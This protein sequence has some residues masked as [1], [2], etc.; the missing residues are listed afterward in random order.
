MSGFDLIS[1]E[2]KKG[3]YS[4]DELWASFKRVFSTKTA[5]SSSYKFVFL[6]SLLDCIDRYNKITYS[7]YEVFERFTEIYWILVVKYGLAQNN[8]PKKET[9]VEQIL[10][11]YVGCTTDDKKVKI[12]FN[13]LTI[14]AKTKIIQQVT[15]KCKKYV[16]GAL[17]GDTEKLIYS[18]S[19]VNEIIELNPLMKDFIIKHS[20]SIEELNYY[21]LTRFIDKVNSQ[22][23]AKTIMND[24]NYK[25]TE[26]QE[27]Y[28]QL[29]YDEFEMNCLFKNKS[30]EYNTIELL[31]EAEEK[32]RESKDFERE[33]E[34]CKKLYDKEVAIEM[35][36][37]D[38]KLYLDDPEK[39]IKML[40]MRHKILCKTNT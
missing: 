2:Y 10:K 37:Q 33:N 18:F 13:D 21:E 28:R 19:K 24:R 11:E 8:S 38:M 26:S 4:E 9:Y 31:M 16:V 1:G 30:V 12:E 34:D 23:K 36:C 29:L 3:E 20:D 7:F 15:K 14:E 40:K 6:K 39:I 17:Y 22:E 27:I 25:L 32:L 5:N 35:D